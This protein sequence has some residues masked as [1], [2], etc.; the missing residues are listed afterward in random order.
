M[1]L[2]PT[3]IFYVLVFLFTGEILNLNM[4]FAVSAV[5][6]LN[7]LFFLS[8]TLMM[9]SL[10]RNSSLVIGVPIGFYLL[11]QILVNF[12]NFLVYI[13]PWGLTNPLSDGTPSIVVSF[14][15]GLQPFSIL[16]I[17]A[18]SMYVIMFVLLTIKIMQKQDI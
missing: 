1:I 11:L 10:Q 4:F 15:L 2:V 18:T 6:T 16:P 13:A 14:I 12:S 17:I 9:G 5:L 8:F 7:M 3:F